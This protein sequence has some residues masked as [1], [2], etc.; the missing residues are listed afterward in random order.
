MSLARRFIR[1]AAFRSLETVVSVLTGLFMLP[2]LLSHLG[3]DVY[4]L[5]IIVTSVTS[6]FYIFD[7]G[8]ATSVTRFMAAALGTQDR[9]KATE[10]VSTALVV[11]SLLAA[12]ILLAVLIAIL[13]AATVVK[14]PSQLPLAQLLIG[15]TGLTL[16]L[17]F[18]FKAYAGIALF[19]MRHDLAALSRMG[20]NLLWVAGTVLAVWAGYSIVSVALIGLT[21][22]MGTNLVFLAIARHLEPEVGFAKNSIRRD[23]FRQLASFSAWTFVGDLLRIVRERNSVWM[24]AGILGTTP[25]ATFYAATRLVSY[26]VSLL[27]SALGMTP[28]LFARTV[29]ESGRQSL[30][31]RLILF[32]SINTNAAMYVIGGFVLFASP[33]FEAWVGTSL[34]AG[35]A[36]KVS[37]IAIVGAVIAFVSSPLSSCLFALEKPRTMAANEALDATISIVAIAVLVGLMDLGIAGAAIGS[38]TATV[39]SRA[40]LLPAVHRQLQFAFRAY[41][42]AVIRPAV[43]FLPLI[44]VALAIQTVFPTDSNLIAIA[45]AAFLYSLVTAAYFVVTLTDDEVALLERNLDHRWIQILIKAR[46]SVRQAIRRVSPAR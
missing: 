35:L 7:L 23:T 37:L 15:I 22:S 40:A 2:F 11:Y 36:A 6:A 19:H 25:L 45:S 12:L 31:E 29:A 34:D 42:A 8:L 17:E 26:A 30:A 44:V 24:T 5:W 27:S 14:D 4:G 16:A 21:T 41:A 33:F 13:F 46:R 28:V 39:L 20:F 38:L 1:S 18:P 43:R 3:Q 9:S 10:I 32:T